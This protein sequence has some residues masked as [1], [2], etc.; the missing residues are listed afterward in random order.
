MY[1]TW[2]HLSG[3]LNQPN[4]LLVHVFTLLCPLKLC[5][6]MLGK[7]F[8]L[9]SLCFLLSYDFVTF[10]HD[11]IPKYINSKSLPPLYCFF[12]L[13]F[14]SKIIVHRLVQAIELSSL[15]MLEHQYIAPLLLSHVILLLISL[16]R[17]KMME[18]GVTLLLRL[19]LLV[20]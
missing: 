14:V 13:L 7:E 16:E 6:H 4:C 17:L 1:S 2:N 5:D 9:C 20:I 8:P 12:Y 3:G 10:L 18:I 11:A 19:S 15:Q